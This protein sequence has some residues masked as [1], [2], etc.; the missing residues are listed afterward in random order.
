MKIQTKIHI[1]R[2]FFTS[3]TGALL[4]L[5]CALAEK[6]EAFELRR[7]AD[8]RQNAL[9]M[10]WPRDMDARFF[11]TGSFGISETR[12]RAWTRGYT[13]G[14]VIN[15]AVEMKAGFMSSG[16]GLAGMFSEGGGIFGRGKPLE[17]WDLT[18]DHIKETST[19][20][21]TRLERL[22]IKWNIGQFDIDIGRQPLSIGTSHFIGVLDVIAPFAPGDLDATYKPGIDALRIRR[23]IG[24]TGE[25]EIIAVGAGKWGEGAILGRYRTLYK[26]IE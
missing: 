1:I 20:L 13:G 25:A 2:V 7:G 11:P 9:M 23:G 19:N 17:R 8:L 10:K 21:S 24:M 6:A 3:L 12:A 15:G 4:L 5:N 22:D 14:L 16:T 26:G 18:A